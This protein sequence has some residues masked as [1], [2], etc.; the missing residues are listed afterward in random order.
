M[1][2]GSHFTSKKDW[3]LAK[4]RTGQGPLETGWHGIGHPAPSSSPQ[5][6]QWGCMG[7]GDQWVPGQRYQGRGHRRGSGKHEV[8]S[9]SHP[10]AG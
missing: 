3:G 10:T 2:L 9:P 1:F 6:P 8:A 5:G 4:S 7:A